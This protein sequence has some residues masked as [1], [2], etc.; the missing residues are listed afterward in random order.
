MLVLVAPPPRYGVK[1]LR[2][3]FIHCLTIRLSLSPSVSSIA[4]FWGG[5]SCACPVPPP[6]PSSSPRLLSGLHALRA[7]PPIC[8][9]TALKGARRG[10]AWTW[11]CLGSAWQRLRTTPRS[12]R[13]RRHAPKP[14]QQLLLHKKGTKLSYR[15]NSCFCLSFVLSLPFSEPFRPRSR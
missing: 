2:P 12:T 10:S 1:H 11:T 7:P 6:F 4:V 8:R 13:Q 5:R 14:F 9:Q 3:L 15:L